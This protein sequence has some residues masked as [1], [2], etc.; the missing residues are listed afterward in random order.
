M[1]ADGT[2]GF[3][4]HD[5]N[6][7]LAGLQ[8]IGKEQGEYYVLAYTPPPSQEGT[9]HVLKVKV[10]RGGTNVRS[11]SGY[12]KAKSKDQLKGSPIEQTLQSRAAA[13]GAGNLPVKMQLPFFY[14]SPNVARVNVALEIDTEKVE[15]K[16]EKGK[17]H[18]ALNV[19]GIAYNPEGGVSARFS[20]T[21]NLDLPDKKAV[22][23]FK[24][25][26]LHYENQFEIA[27]GKYNL[28]VLFGA[29]GDNFGK[30]EQPLEV[31]AYDSSQ[32]ALSGLALSQ[33]ARPSAAGALDLDSMLEDRT[34]LLVSGIQVIPSGSNL[35]MKTGTAIFY[36]EIYEPMLVSP[37][38][39]QP[40]VVAI[41]MKVF[42][43]KTGQQKEDTGLMRLQLPEATGSPVIPVGEKMPVMKLDPGSYR[44]E[45]TAADIAGKQVTRTADFELE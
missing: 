36:F 26:P 15:F 6:D 40:A 39:K 17:M 4:I 20:D 2:G 7:I 11:R 14:T 29:G 32:F 9:C 35:F 10:D 24:E 43:R 12:C 33:A 37:D 19:L 8:K 28:K 18:A 27:S 3:V 41:E 38:P 5:T 45:L 23:A 21:V 1:L 34:P 13:P 22:E 42:D 44:L 30:V 31:D 16:K 25:K